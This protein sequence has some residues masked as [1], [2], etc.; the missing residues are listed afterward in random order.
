MSEW[1]DL[2]LEELENNKDKEDEAGTAKRI[3]QEAFQKVQIS[4]FFGAK[5]VS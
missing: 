4:L 3:A 1:I 5:T 2:T